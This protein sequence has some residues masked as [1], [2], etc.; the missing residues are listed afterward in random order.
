MLIYVPKARARR[1][2]RGSNA[3]SSAGAGVPRWLRGGRGEGHGPEE[4]VVEEP[5][6]GGGL[7]LRSSRHSRPSPGSGVGGAVGVGK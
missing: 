4:P 3:G 2:L 7:S 1:R 5:V 6:P